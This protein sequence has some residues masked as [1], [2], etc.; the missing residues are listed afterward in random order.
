LYA[1]RLANDRV[2]M[3][4][5]CP[6][7]GLPERGDIVFVAEALSQ[8]VSLYRCICSVDDGDTDWCGILHDGKYRP[9]AQSLRFWGPY[10]QGAQKSQILT[11]NISKTVSR[12]VTCQLELKISSTRAF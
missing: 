2:D 5:F 3:E 9:R 4:K 1:S 7:Q 11:S 8:N 12:I 6:Q 10:S